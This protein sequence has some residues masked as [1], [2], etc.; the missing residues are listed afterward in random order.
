MF[1]LKIFKIKIDPKRHENSS[2]IWHETL[3][4]TL[5]DLH[6]R[7]SNVSRIKN[8][9]YKIQ[10]TK[11]IIMQA[12]YRVINKMKQKSWNILNE[13]SRKWYEMKSNLAT[14]H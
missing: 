1:V 6:L 12:Y 7:V 10:S 4:V 11:I 13:I 3:L 9:S 5:I 8:T 2:V 14:A